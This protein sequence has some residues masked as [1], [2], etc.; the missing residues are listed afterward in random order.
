MAERSEIN[1]LL[2]EIA[3]TLLGGL[4]SPDSGS[5]AGDFLAI[6]RGIITAVRAFVKTQPLAGRDNGGQVIAVNDESMR[7][8][9]IAGRLLFEEFSDRDFNLQSFYE[10]CSKVKYQFSHRLFQK[11]ISF[12]LL[13]AGTILLDGFF[14]GLAAGFVQR[15]IRIIKAGWRQRLQAAKIYAVQEK[16]RYATVFGQMNEPAFVV[17]H[18]LQ[19]I[20]VNPACQNFFGIS[21]AAL[22]G[23]TCCDLIGQNRCAV[24]PLEKI[25]NTGGSF[26]NIEIETFLPVARAE[27]SPDT[28]IILVAGTALGNINGD[29][30]GAIVIFQDITERKKIEQELDEYQDRLEDLVDERTEDLIAANDKLQLEIAERR[31][32][33]NELIQVT[34]ALKRSNIELEQ[35]AYVASHDL[36]EPLMLVASFAGRLKVRYGPLLDE[37]GSEYLDRIIRGTGK[38]QNLVEAIL[39]L[40]KVSTCAGSFEAIEMNSLVRDVV[41][42]LDEIINFSGARVD[43]KPLPELPGDEVQIR[44]LFQNLISNAVKYCR[45]NEPPHVSISSRVLGDFCEITVEDNGIGFEE[46]DVE[47]IFEPFVRL[48]YRKNSEGAG[49]GLATCKKIV[50][51]HGGEIMAR[52]KPGSGAAFVVKL[53]LCLDSP[54]DK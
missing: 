18:K 16:K 54:A 42:D 14:S 48:Q 52:S 50:L 8:G 41:D 3:D 35:F 47:R 25:I 9:N 45:E 22:M 5:S 2:T 23:L 33:E 40:S 30:N 27:A 4:T 29:T 21:R 34:A 49:M 43:I 53:P 11:E 44:Q 26:S 37:R 51:R 1:D 28:K 20:D 24:C 46:K 13:Q 7:L 10:R 17:D 12:D 15:T 39:Q 6:D 19:V 38:L 32:V 31:Y 36:Q